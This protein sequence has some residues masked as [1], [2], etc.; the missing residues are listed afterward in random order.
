MRTRVRR[1]RMGTRPAINAVCGVVFPTGARL[2][3]THGFF[4]FLETGKVY[5]LR[6]RLQYVCKMSC[7]ILG[8]LPVLALNGGCWRALVG[9]GMPFGRALTIAHVTV[10]LITR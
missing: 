10:N 5:V 8:N 4:L 1:W 6:G 9:F 3:D 2:G 7:C